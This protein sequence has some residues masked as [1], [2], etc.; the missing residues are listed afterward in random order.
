MH[1]K[2]VGHKPVISH[3]GVDFS[4]GKEDKYVYIEPA[5]QMLDF[6]S[7]LEN[8]KKSSINPSKLLDEQNILSILHK[9]R[10]DFNIFFKENISAYEK[11][12]DDEILDVNKITRLNNVEKEVLINNLKFMK[13][14]RLQRVTN[15][16]VYEELI[17]GCIEIIEKKGVLSIEMP[18]SLTFVH[19]ASSFESSLA[20]INRAVVANVE[21]ILDREQPYTRL[22][23]HGFEND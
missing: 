16:L 23:V 7:K 10:P 22:T 14:Y 1:L 15:K 17:N 2:Y 18:F 13:A 21:V 8:K 20:L 9:N 4:I 11:K 12:L 3:S 19:V 6:L 5:A